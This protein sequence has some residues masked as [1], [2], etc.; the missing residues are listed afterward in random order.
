MKKVIF[1]FDGFNFYNGL[2]DK[3]K[4]DA[5]WKRYYWIDFV[6][7][8]SQFLPDTQE[9]VK[10]KYFT[11]PPQNPYKRSRQATLFAAN[12]L[13]NQEKFEIIKGKYIDKTVGCKICGS[14]FQ[15]PEE[16]RTDVNISCHMLLDC[17]KNNADK[18]ILVTAD[19]DLIPT[20][21]CIKQN[22]PDKQFKIYFPP[23]RTSMDLINL[24]KPV[25]FLENN[26]KKFDAA[27]MEDTI[28]KDGKSFTKPSQ[29]L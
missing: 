26:P 18:L 19:S 6:K 25:V 21:E 29:W 1:Y 2:K 12:S 23:F 10:V 27:I 7:F 4:K 14:P 28:S 9:L 17:F 24:C 8:C 16:K 22:F 5:V 3:C 13:I 20:I 11:A 15:V